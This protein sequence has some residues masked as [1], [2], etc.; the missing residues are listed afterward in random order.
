MTIA[1]N[2]S[3]ISVIYRYGITLRL[4]EIE[5]AEFILKLRNDKALNKFISYTSPEFSEQV[6]WIQ[7]YKKRE[8]AGQEFYYIAQDQF[9]NEYG[10][11]RIYNF[12]D[13]SF[14]IGS[15]V[16]HLN[17]P[18]G[19]AVKAH[20][21]GYEIG[22]ENLNL[23]YCRFEVRKK[24]A[25]VLR[26]LQDFE[27]TFIKEDDLNV[28]FTLTKD[29]FYTRRNSLSI[30]K[31]YLT[32]SEKKYFIHPN[33][34]VQTKKIGEGTYIWQYC[35]VLKGAEIG[36]NC[37]LNYNVFVE[38]D[39]IIGD[40]VTIKSGTQLWDGIRLEDNVFISPNVTFTNDF[41]P[42]SK[43]YPNKF[44]ETTVKYG[45]SIGAN[46]TIIGGITIG[47]Y[48]MLGAGSVVTKNIPDNTLWY[49]NPAVFKAFICSCGQKLNDQLFC[50]QCKIQYSLINGMIEMI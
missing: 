24:N 15:W 39:V 49:G 2:L 10:T 17:S 47:K 34:E 1:N 23:Q 46:C 31:S 50:N 18:I 45:A 6:K 16:F 42:R 25:A 21:I 40:N 32:E 12:D 33:A 48:A 35:I 30:F 29:N 44:L 37:N 4:V 38:N 22:F 9:G 7:D 14:E 19:M 26:Y 28:Y 20:F 36:K 43:H 8:A 27:K 41:A 11:I 13:E 5:D 3:N